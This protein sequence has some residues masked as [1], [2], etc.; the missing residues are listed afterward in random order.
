VLL[1]RSP[2]VLHAKGSKENQGRG[3]NVIIKKEAAL[4]PLF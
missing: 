3:K 1:L 2:P 4:Q